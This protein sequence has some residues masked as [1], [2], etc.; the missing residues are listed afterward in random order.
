MLRAACPEFPSCLSE[1]LFLGNR[2]CASLLLFAM[3]CTQLALRMLDGGGSTVL[4]YN[5]P[6]ASSEGDL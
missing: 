2:V 6:E 1:V 4:N 5:G 3:A